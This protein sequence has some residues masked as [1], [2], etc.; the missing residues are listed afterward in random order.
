MHT[1]RA[2]WGK[3]KN[4]LLQPS[5][6][7]PSD[8]NW[9]SYLQCNPDLVNAGIGTEELAIR[10]YLLQ[11]RSENRFYS[12]TLIVPNP[13]YENASVFIAG[14]SREIQVFENKS[15]VALLEEKLPVFCI[16]T[17]FH[18][19]NH[20]SCLFVNGRFQQMKVDG[21]ANKKIDEI[22][23]PFPWESSGRTVRNFRLNVNSDLYCPDI[24]CDLNNP[25]P[26]GPTMLLD[27]VFPFCAFQK[28]RT[29]YILGAEYDINDFGN[30]RHKHDLSYINRTKPYIDRHLEY[31]FAVQK[32]NVWKDYFSRNQIECFALSEKSKTPFEKR[33]L[34]D[35]LKT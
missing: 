16:N 18:Y 28:V 26:P 19:F 4:F 10:H 15:L 3:L 30:M 25:L 13:K 31:Q 6:A 11:G 33:S 7:L 29:I 34:W 27:I 24:S 9:N 2:F 35:F 8:F 32:L 12:H 5:H 17:A 22:Y 23:A 21:L 14:T 1:Y 20:I